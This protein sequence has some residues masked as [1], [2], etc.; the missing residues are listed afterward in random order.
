[1]EKVENGTFRTRKKSFTIVDNSILDD[2]SISL[3]GKGLYCVIARHITNPNKILYRSQLKNYMSDGDSSFN[4][5][6]KELKNK[7]YLKTHIYPNNGNFRTE[8]ELLETPQKGA[9]HTFYY[10]RYGTLNS[11]NVTN[12]PP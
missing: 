12:H 5:A 11:T 2:S 10:N 7:G 4:S 8:Y 9:V 3:K 1:M 6:W